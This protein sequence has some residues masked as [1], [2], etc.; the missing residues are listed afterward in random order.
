[1]NLFHTRYRYLYIPNV[2]KIILRFKT[3]SINKIILRSQFLSFACMH[4]Y[5]FV[6]NYFSYNLLIDSQYLYYANYSQIFCLALDRALNLRQKVQYT[7][8]QVYKCD[9]LNSLMSFQLIQ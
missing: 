1:M 5:V 2:E 9:N 6:R 7:V 8:E 4:R 3:F